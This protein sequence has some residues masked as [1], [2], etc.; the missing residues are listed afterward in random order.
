MLSLVKLLSYNRY[1]LPP[2]DCTCSY[3]PAEKHRD[4]TGNYNRPTNKVV[5]SNWCIPF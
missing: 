3:K 5:I 1:W 2:F 4:G